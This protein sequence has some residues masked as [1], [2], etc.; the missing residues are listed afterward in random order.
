MRMRLNPFNT[1]NINVRSSGG[2]GV[3]GGKAGGL[4]GLPRALQLVEDQEVL[5][6]DSGVFCEINQGQCSKLASQVITKSL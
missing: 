3:P 5:F 2:G 1:G 4:G 6:N